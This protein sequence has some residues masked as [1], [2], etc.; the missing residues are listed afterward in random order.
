M[1]DSLPAILGGTPMLSAERHKP[2]PHLNDD[3]RAAVNRVLDRGVLSGPFAPEAT[4]LQ[5]EFAAYCGVKHCL[6]TH[7]GTSALHLAV[8]AAGIEPGDEVITTAFTFIATP[9]SILQHQALPVFVDIDPQTFNLDPAKV[10]A[11]ITPRTKAIMPVHIHGLTAEMDPLLDLAKKHNLKIIEDAAQ[12]HGAKYRG[13]TAG[14]IGLSGGFSLQSSKNF[15]V[16]EG[17]LFVT[18]DTD[19]AVRANR[20]RNF[21]ENVRPSEY[22]TFSPDLPLDGT[23]AY[24]S[25]TVGWMYR[26]QEMNAA[27]G[28]SRLKRLPQ[29]TERV[30]RNAH[31][32]IEGFSGLPGIRAQFEPE[33]CT[34]VWHK[35]RIRLDAVAAGVKEY[36][37]DSPT[38]FRDCLRQAISD[39]D[40]EAVLWQTKAVC[41]QGLF[42]EKRGFGHGIPWTLPGVREIDYSLGQFPAT[43][44]LLDNSLCLFSQSHPLIA[45]PDDV[46]DSYVQM[47]RRIWDHLPAVAK[48]YR[49]N[50]AATAAAKA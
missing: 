49:E 20:L 37:P 15:S 47:L 42:R 45:Q 46:I 23:R 24:E 48:K 50:V 35:F 33:H 16:G 21:G 44:A 40:G 12:A 1:A 31:R 7:S 2:W 3:D 13:R 36:L 10:E 4:A 18:N 11:A 43:Q 22:D 27:L 29:D 41:G 25:M 28:R 30:R 34:S 9:M 17:G 6:M 5:E 39:D 32:L 14:S 19:Q 26:G 8:A 38:A